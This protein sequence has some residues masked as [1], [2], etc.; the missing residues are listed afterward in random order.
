MKF[1]LLTGL[2]QEDGLRVTA[3]NFDFK[4]GIATFLQHKTGTHKTIAINRDLRPLVKRMIARVGKR[5]PIVQMHKS[6]L[7][8]N[9]ANARDRAGLPKSITFHSLRHTFAT[10]LAA[11]GTDFKTLQELIGHRSQE[12]T[13]IY[14]HGSDPNKRSAIRLLRLPRRKAG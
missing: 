3:A 7:T 14:V 9:F 12:S 5:E 13:Q 8:A 4:P 6:R 11:L 10:W 2:R 1:Y